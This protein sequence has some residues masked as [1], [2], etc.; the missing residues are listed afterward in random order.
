MTT[1]VKIGTCGFGVSKV[2]YARS[3]SCVE[4]QNTFYQ[5]PQISTLERWRQGVPTSFEFTLKA[6][7]LITHEARSPTYR[8]LKKKLSEIEK[9]ET[10]FFKPTSIVREAWEVTR[11]CA[12]ALK[13]R[14]IL[15]QCPASFTQTKENVSN[16]EEFF[17]SIDRGDFN[18][19][20]E[21]RGV[22]DKDVVRSICSDL[23]LS[24]AV[25]PFLAKTVT[26]RKSYFRLHG[27]TGWKYKYEEGELRELAAMLAKRP[28]P[29]VFFNNA[30]M[31]SDALRFRAIVAEGGA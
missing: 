13:A 7:Q 24:H 25:D 12:E 4:V 19:C 1:K 3:F 21:P 23:K 14:T 2:E 18:F 20:W 17:S 16:L 6:W 26:P 11:A 9:H 27:R 28:G 30:S 29:Y 10:G 31:T 5:P 15:F 22:W 8:R